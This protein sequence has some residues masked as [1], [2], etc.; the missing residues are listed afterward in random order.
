MF[1]P[2]L[3]LAAAGAVPASDLPAFLTGCWIER[4]GEDWTE[5]CWT[6]AEGGVML[7]SGRE[8]RGATIRHWEWMRIE[9]EADGT[10]A[11]HASPKGAPPVRFAATE[12]GPQSIAFANPGHDYPQRVSYRRALPS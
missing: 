5:E 11:F 6:T 10:L 2:L 4:R 9:R 8:G 12:A 3:I 1:A 7:G